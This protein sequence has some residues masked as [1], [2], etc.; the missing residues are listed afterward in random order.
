VLFG[1][2]RTDEPDQGGTIR[3]DSDHIGSPADFLI[4]ALL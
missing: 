1:Q 2:D 3:E 4:E